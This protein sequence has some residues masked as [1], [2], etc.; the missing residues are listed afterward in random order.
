[1]RLKGIVILVSL[2]LLM[3]PAFVS[4]QATCGDTL[5]CSGT[6]AMYIKAQSGTLGLWIRAQ[7]TNAIQAYSKSK[8]ALL[9]VSPNSHAA[10]FISEG[11]GTHAVWATSESGNAVY[12]ESYDLNGIYGISTGVGY[13]DNGVYGTTNSTSSTEAGVFGYSSA[14]GSCGVYGNSASGSG[15]RGET[16]RADGNYGLY[17]SDNAYIGG[18][19][20]L[21]GVVDPVIGERFEL[22]P[23]EN[24]E[25]GD[26]VVV[27]EDSQYLTRCSEAYDA[28]VIG[29]VGPEL[30]VKDGE[31]MVITFGNRAANRLP[32]INGETP[33][34]VII[35]IK[36]DAKYGMIKRG[37][38]L[39]T[40]PTPGHAMKAVPVEMNGIKIYPPGTIIAIALESLESG[41]GTLEVFV[42]KM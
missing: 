21:G 16:A 4:A 40:S 22:D 17:T 25:V 10:R 3:L 27:D 12:G 6:Y 34:R 1:M 15:V 38:L 28:K 30:D 7:N 35:K 8:I 31:T 2:G 26:V 39:T 32:E 42:S 20:D 36:A 29:V 14:N 23:D 37:D 5:D 11:S 41:K 13:A 18:K 24:I 19:L 9:T 33:A